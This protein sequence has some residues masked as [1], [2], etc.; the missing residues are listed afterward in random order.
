MHGHNSKQI[1]NRK[2]G[3]EIL[4]PALPHVGWL[5]ASLKLGLSAN[6]SL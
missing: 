5:Q 4:A 2:A 6:E 1:W 3:F